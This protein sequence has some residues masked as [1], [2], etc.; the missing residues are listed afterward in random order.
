VAKQAL[1]YI[2]QNLQVTCLNDTVELA[3]LQGQGRVEV[4]YFYDLRRRG[5]SGAKLFGEEA[6]E[7]SKK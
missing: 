7:E 6:D 2:K 4:E 3:I 5:G 1:S